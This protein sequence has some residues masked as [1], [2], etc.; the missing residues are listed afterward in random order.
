M[1]QLKPKNGPS[2]SGDL[3]PAV[4]YIGVKFMKPDEEFRG[5]Y[6][7]TFKKMVTNDEGREYERKT[8]YFTATAPGQIRKVN[9]DTG[10]TTYTAYN[11]GDEV[12]INGTAQLDDA[13]LGNDVQ[14]GTKLIVI[15]RGTAKNKKSKGS[16]QLVDVFEDDGSSPAKASASQTDA[17]KSTGSVLTDR[18]AAVKAANSK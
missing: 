4:G 2:A 16:T 18:I 13:I 6:R 11:V 14:A 17:P 9:A 3:K 5:T 8:H 10:E 7:S 1:K 15:K 12:G